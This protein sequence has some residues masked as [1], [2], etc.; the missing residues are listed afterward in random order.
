MKK[1]KYIILAFL[2]ITVFSCDMGGEPEIGGTGVQEM[3]GEWWV[4]LYDNKGELVV[5]YNL[6][7]TSSTAKNSASEMLLYDQAHF[8]DIKAKVVS[9]IANLKLMGTDILNINFA[10]TDEVPKTKPVVPIGAVSV[11]SSNPY[12]FTLVSSGIFKNKYKAP[13]GANTDSISIGIEP[14]YE[15]KFFVAEK[16][17][18]DSLAGKLDTT[19]IWKYV[20]TKKVKHDLYYLRG[21]KR[22]GFLEDEH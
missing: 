1:Y 21:Y 8:E 7:T 13:S 14:T 20:E 16:Y 15:D 4:E 19:M 18:I 12:S 17:K 9:D 6:I 3:S 5:D 10:P 11:T 2:S 22:T